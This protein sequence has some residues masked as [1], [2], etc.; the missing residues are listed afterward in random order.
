M[1]NLAEYPFVCTHL[2]ATRDYDADVKFVK[3]HLEYT[4]VEEMC[5]AFLNK[6]DH[7]LCERVICKRKV[8]LF[9]HNIKNAEPVE[10]SN[11]E[12]Y[13]DFC[14]ANAQKLSRAMS[15]AD[16]CAEFETVYIEHKEYNA[17]LLPNGESLIVLRV[18]YLQ[19]VQG[20]MMNLQWISFK[21]KETRDFTWLAYPG[22]FGG[23][24][25]PLD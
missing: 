12:E 15:M 17:G 2:D 24:L 1:S 25:I 5:L 6:D 14:L 18:E 13:E 20:E 7:L 22:P 23:K 10:Y 16:Q 8:D 21:Q 9:R 4:M 3:D 19:K 11:K